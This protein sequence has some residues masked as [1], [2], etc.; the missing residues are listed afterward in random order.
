MA[1]TEGPSDIGPTAGDCR[2]A[3]GSSV[4]VF[5]SL[6][7]AARAPRRSGDQGRHDERQL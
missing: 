3:I 6:D 2:H 1:K 4:P 7:K 5:G